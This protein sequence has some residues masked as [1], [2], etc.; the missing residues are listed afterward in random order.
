MKIQ[1]IS[2]TG[3]TVTLSNGGGSFT[4]SVNT[5]SAG[6]NITIDANNVISATDNVDD[7]DADA[8]N[9]IEL[10]T[11]PATGAMNYWD[12]TAWVE[13]APATEGSTLQFMNG[14][15]TWIAPPPPAIGDFRDGGVVFWI[16]PSDPTS[17]LVVDTADLA[18]FA[19]WGCTTTLT[20]A[21]ESAIGT[22]AQN[23][24]DIVAAGC[25]AGGAAALCEASTNGG[26]NDWF[27]PSLDEL[28]EIN[29]N[30]ATINAIITLNGGTVIRTTGTL[31]YYWSS[32]ESEFGA[33]LA[34]CFSFVSGGPNLNLS[35][36][37][38]LMVRAVRAF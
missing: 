26:F 21:D 18:L 30:T 6:T 36:T 19:N 28:A 38:T 3:T 35:K 15:P 1:T 23:T 2:R 29:T 17:G 27:L 8:T 5:Y 32:T 20:G 37:A 13:L 34:H 16:D 22:G 31:D 14:A 25:A 10:P 33:S 7:A 24:I 11:A 12:G 9:E 4:D